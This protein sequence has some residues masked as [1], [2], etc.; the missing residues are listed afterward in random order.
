M[1]ILPSDLIFYGSANMPDVDGATTGGAIDRTK[2]ISFAD[3]AANGTVNYVSGGAGD[4]AVTL[5]TTG[6]DASGVVQAEAKVL[7]GTTPV[8]GGQTYE[9][10]RK[11]V[12]TGTAA[13]NDVAVISNTPVLTARTATGGAAATSS[14]AATIALQTG[15]GASVAVGQII[16]IMTNTGAF[17]LRMIIALSG[18]TASVNR[19]WA[20]V[21]DAT[22]TYNVHRGALLPILPQPVT[23]VRRP[24]Y[25]A[26][27][28]IVGGATRTYYEKVFADNQNATLALTVATIRK[29]VDPSGGAT[30]QF[31]LETTLS[32]TGT[33]AN[34]QTA[35]AAIGA[36]TA[37]A[38]PQS[39]AVVGSTN[40]A[41]AGGSPQGVWLSLQLAAALPATKTSETMQI[42]GSST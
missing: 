30:F 38:S 8:A 24:F 19:P 42:T 33:T 18:D 32:G 36:F 5:T 9:R 15:D 27:S 1:S 29:T 21:P 20:T 13:T 2:L 4:T 40:L 37:G 10:L 28:D 23:Q 3:M 22:S 39:S 14:T 12:A 41:A 6:L 31:A 17:Q 35:P 34:R 16:R 7:T 25:A 11:V 26:S